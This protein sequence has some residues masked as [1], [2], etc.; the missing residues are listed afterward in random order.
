MKIMRVVSAIS[1]VT[2]FI[3]YASIDPCPGYD[4]CTEFAE[5]IKAGEADPMTA[6]NLI[7]YLPVADAKTKKFILDA[8]I[9]AV[10]NKP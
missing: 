4:T 10:V 9:N 1:I 3:V 5:G 8:K 2:F 6:S 7:Q